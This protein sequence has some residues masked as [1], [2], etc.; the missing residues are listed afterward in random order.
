MALRRGVGLVLSVI[1]LAILA[2]LVAVVGTW[3]WMSAEPAIP[4]DATLVVR[5]DGDF[6]ETEP[7][8]VIGSFLRTRP[9]IRSVLETLRRAR[10]DERIR[11][12]LV[13]PGPTSMGWARTQELR[14]AILDFRGAGK[15]T[16]ALL[17]GGGAQE[18]YL[19][20]ACERVDLV[21]SATLDLAGLARY[22]LFLR[23]TLDKLGIAPDLLHIGD[24]K[25]AI[26]TF[27]E[28][29]Y[30][31]A[32]REMMESL[33]ADTF[34]Q[35]VDDIAA[36]RDRDP[37]AMRAALGAGPHLPDTALQAGLIDDV[38]Y[39]DQIE[40][41]LPGGGRGL[42]GFDE[43]RG[44]ALAD[45]LPRARPR[46]RLALIYA[47]GM[48]S[49]GESFDTA[50]GG[51]VGSDTLVEY[52]RRVG[53]DERVKAVVVRIDSPGGSAVASDIIWRELM[54][55]RARKPLVVSMG[56]AA[57]SG[58]YYMALP[59][60]VIVA[61]PATLTGSIGIFG[62][63]VVVEG[64]MR[65][66]GAA[67]EG[68]KTAPRADM[69]SPLRPYTPEERGLVEEQLQAF[70]DSFVEKVADA[71]H[72]TPEQVDGIAQGRVWTGRQAKELGLVDEL[73]GLERAVAAARERAKL[74]PDAEID[75]EIYPPRRVISRFV[76]NPFADNG[77]T[78]LGVFG[79][80]LSPDEQRAVMGAQLSMRLLRRRE[81]LALMPLFVR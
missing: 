51:I 5:I 45:W 11:A 20:S 67:A 4:P 69:H 59:A 21:P 66:L 24:Y 62:G 38:A 79:A 34:A 3:W 13:V 9:T 37:A 50:D 25:T 18:Y 43:Y 27:T 14:N 75:I 61:Q 30:T 52:I 56:D 8:G 65:K 54:L 39:R 26:N 16:F 63:K 72:T 35:L 58:G 74:A 22:D 78:R 2:S 36:S 40:A 71:R 32:H 73:G 70:Y 49:T 28:K 46:E 23:G 31:A 42:V 57:A 76:P 47:S 15:P 6:G 80:L 55:L 19:A 48:I 17:E 53:R 81:P 1:L 77:I 33:T 64:A 44:S 12:L 10:D 7:G 68:V 41:R 60:H 29:G